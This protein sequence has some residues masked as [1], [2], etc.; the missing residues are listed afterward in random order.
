MAHIVDVKTRKKFNME[1]CVAN[2]TLPILAANTPTNASWPSSNN[3]DKD[4][5][6]PNNIMRLQRSYVILEDDKE[7]IGTLSIKVSNRLSLVILPSLLIDNL[8]SSKPNGDP[9]FR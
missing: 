7:M 8:L 1:L 4:N 3:I 9:F 6:N 5:G 2:A